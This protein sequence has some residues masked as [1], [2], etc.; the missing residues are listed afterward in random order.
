MVDGGRVAARGF[1]YQ[2]QRTL[3]ALLD[4]IEEGEAATCR[5]EGDPANESIA[6]DAIDFDIVGSDGRVLLAAQ[7]KSTTAR[8]ALSPAYVIQILDR[9]TARQDAAAYQIL[10]NGSISQ[11]VVDLLE[12][13]RGENPP[14][15]KR[16]RLRGL[17][18][19]EIARQAVAQFSDDRLRRL[20][21]CDILVDDRSQGQLRAAL[22]SKV[23]RARVRMGLASGVRCGG[24]LLACLLSEVH[25]RA[26][27]SERAIWS[28]SEL[29]G[30]LALDESSLIDLLGSRDRGVVFGLMAPIPD[31]LRDDLLEKLID[32]LPP[33]QDLSGVPRLCQLTG[34]SGIGKSSMAAAFIGQLADT[35]SA[36]YWIDASTQDSLLDG[37]RA[38]A[39]SLGADTDDVNQMRRFVHERLSA[40]EGRWLLVLDDAQLKSIELYLPRF[41][42]GDVIMTSIDSVSR[43]RSATVI[44]VPAMQLSQAVAMVAARLE[45]RY[46]PASADGALMRRLVNE[47]DCWPLAIELA[48]GY[49]LSCGYDVRAVP[50]YL[51]SLKLRSLDDLQSVPFGY[52]RTLVAAIFL[53]LDLVETAEDSVVAEVAS[54]VLKFSAY[55]AGRRI[56]LHLVTVAGDP[57]IDELPAGSGPMIVEDPRVMEVLRLLRQVSVVRR[58]VDLPSIE[59]A[60]PTANVTFSMN[61]VF[62]EVVRGRLE[63]DSRFWDRTGALD[64]LAYHLV[65][66]K[67]SAGHNGEVGRVRS[68]LPHCTTLL[69]HFVRLGLGSRN[70]ALLMGNIATLYAAVQRLDEAVMLLK[71]ELDL[72]G[73]LDQYDEFLC[74]QVQLNLAAALAQHEY[75]TEEQ[76]AEAVG[77]LEST[78]QYCA[79]LALNGDT[80]QQSATFCVRSLNVLDS[81]ESAGHG[82]HSSRQLAGVFSEIM[83]RLPRT[84]EVDVREAMSMASVSLSEGDCFDAERRCLPLLVETRYGTNAQLEVRRIL[85]EAYIGQEK[86]PEAN[87]QLDAFAAAAGADPVY[88]STVQ[89]AL[90]NIGLVLSIRALVETGP[91]RSLFKKVMET[92]CFRSIVEAAEDEY[93]VKFD[94][95]SLALATLVGND[96]ERVRL[97]LEVERANMPDLGVA[98][99]AVWAGIMRFV[100]RIAAS[101]SPR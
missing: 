13:L 47:L 54:E 94:T 62:Q 15:V 98:Q 71:A 95:F 12:V 83:S 30:T 60:F 90:H 88:R 70:V 14:D 58:D 9:L 53:A 81:I 84:Y 97:T 72:L 21:R 42:C 78:L 92:P 5:V 67:T 76:C 8:T 28:V 73:S 16:E 1:L 66:W 87:D 6:I 80:H 64:R 10:T 55:L 57:S 93:R 59:D 101:G 35:Y 68:L 41:G 89:F 33:S 100:L 44:E 24:L 34:L 63:S 79:G 85:L 46:D 17:L 74:N 50:Q 26:A 18:K 86:W 43:L 49:M 51:E 19:S 38:I 25:Q 36:I 20:E 61:S 32:A 91:P 48:S 7:V 75:P 99:N 31:I 3:E 27:F 77:Y 39:K 23:R 37:F 65:I 11:A 40:A 45:S 4:L 2:Y 96:A 56:P 52:P 69:R 29:A 22:I 82:N